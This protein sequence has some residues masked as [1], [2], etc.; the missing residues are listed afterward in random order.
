MILHHSFVS[1]LHAMF[2]SKSLN[3]FEI[4]QFD[5]SKNHWLYPRIGAFKNL[6]QGP[7]ASTL[8]SRSLQIYSQAIRVVSFF[9]STIGAAPKIKKSSRKVQVQFRLSWKTP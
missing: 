7:E 4:Y 6:Q 5:V 8:P 1:Q 2:K 3:I 9:D